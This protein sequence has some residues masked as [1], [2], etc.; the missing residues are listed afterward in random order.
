MLRPMD[1]H[2]DFKRAFKGYDVE[3]VDEFV[4]KIVSH[5]ESLYQENQRLQEQIEALKAEVQ[6]KQNREQDVLDLISLTKQSVAEIRDIA[7]TRAA[8][9]LDEAERQAAVKLSE[10]EARLNVVKRTERLFKERMRA[11][12][13]A[14]WKML[15]ESQLEEVDEETKIYR[16]MAAS[17]REELPEQD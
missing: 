2:T 16:N 5:Y 17:V 14:T 8:A 4:A 10:A 3:E 15:E 13:E 7:N 12:M 1:I 9:I 11:V 6:K